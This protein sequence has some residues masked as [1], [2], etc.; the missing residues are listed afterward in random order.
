[1]VASDA[2]ICLP[3]MNR[4]PELAISLYKGLEPRQ[5]MK[6]S[7][8]LHVYWRQPNRGSALVLLKI[9]FSYF[10]D[11][12]SSFW[13]ALLGPFVE[14]F[15][16]CE[17]EAGRPHLHISKNTSTQHFR[18]YTADCWVVQ[19]QILSRCFGFILL[20]ISEFFGTFLIQ[21]ILLSV[22][23]LLSEKRA[24]TDLY[25]YISSHQLAQLCQMAKLVTVYILD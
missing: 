19:A 21:G 7:Q 3:L 15:S 13:L 17:Q 22:F 11:C 6:V 25:I 8:L 5:M 24:L 1:M 14:S 2:T 4:Y 18:S 20:L 9:D 23:G 16:R 10:V 12:R